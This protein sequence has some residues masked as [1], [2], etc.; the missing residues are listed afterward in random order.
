MEAI[1]NR[2][3]AVIRTSEFWVFAGQVIATTF[4][5]PV[6]EVYKEIGWGYIIFRIVSKL[7]RYIFPNGITGKW[8]ANDATPAVSSSTSTTVASKE[9]Q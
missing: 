2:I 6:P 1:W 4:A 3:L 8:F 7:A 9:G 5:T